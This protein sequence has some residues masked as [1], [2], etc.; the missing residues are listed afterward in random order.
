VGVHLGE[1]ALERLGEL[2]GVCITLARL[3][4]AALRSTGRTGSGTFAV[5]V[6]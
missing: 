4:L 6:R 5:K 1:R 3:E 2:L